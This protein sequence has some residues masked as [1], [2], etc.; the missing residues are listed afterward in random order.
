VNSPIYVE[1]E[2][3]LNS[4]VA[5]L[6]DD[7]GIVS[8]IGFEAIE[9][10]VEKDPR[11]PSGESW[12]SKTPIY[13]LPT[14]IQRVEYYSLSHLLSEQGIP[15]S[16]MIASSGPSIKRSGSITFYL[17]VLYPSQGIWAEYT[18]VTN[19]SDV[20]SVIRSCPVNAHIRMNLYPPG[21]PDAFYASSNRL[22]RTK[23]DKPLEEATSMS[24]SS[25]MKPFKIQL[26]NV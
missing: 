2:Q 26:I 18:T 9:E 20:G 12:L 5:Y 10:K 3:H 25:S 8:S 16:V 23:T 22:G 7:N 11:D 1:G 15:T 13:G 21:N 6:Y 17:V 19:E 14:F 4:W 24:L